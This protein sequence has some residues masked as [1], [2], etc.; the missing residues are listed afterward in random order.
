MQKKGTAILTFCLN[1]AFL[2]SIASVMAQADRGAGLPAEALPKE[3]KGL[4][5]KDQFVS[6]S[7]KRVGVIHALNGNMV[8]IH[9]VAKWQQI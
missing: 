6:T 3:L 7:L 2:F 4:E 5:I 8:V 1:L 9:M